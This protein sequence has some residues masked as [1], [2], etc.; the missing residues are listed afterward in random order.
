MLV[1]DAPELEV[2]MLRR[3]LAA[4]FVAGAFVF[5]GGALDAE[6]RDQAWTARCP[7]RTDADASALLGVSR[8]GLGYWVAAV[9]ETF[10][11][12]GVLLARSARTGRPVDGEHGDLAVTR[13]AL[14]RGETTFLDLARD[15]DLVLD[16]A[17]IHPVAHW[18]TPPGSPRRYDTRFFLAAAPAGHAYT[19]DDGENVAARWLRP[20]DALDALARNEIDLIL[21]TVRSLMLLARFDCATDLLDVVARATRRPPGLVAEPA[22]GTRIALPFDVDEGAA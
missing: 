15:A 6:D 7:D 4:D 8:G 5:P 14:N 18:V 13:D 21:P 20:A 12:A 16:T 11:E 1:R 3:N 2:F 10:E 22:G 17:A 9:R 19:H